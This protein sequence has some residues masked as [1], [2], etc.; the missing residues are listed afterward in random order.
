[1][2]VVGIYLEHG[3]SHRPFSP[4]PTWVGAE[5]SWTKPSCSNPHLLDQA[6]LEEAGQAL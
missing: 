4:L 2:Y 1:M 3:Q 5:H 6:A